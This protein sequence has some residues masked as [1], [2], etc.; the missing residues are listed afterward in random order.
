MGHSGVPFKGAKGHG[1]TFDLYT[2]TYVH[3]FKHE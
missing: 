2:C 3:Q 1:D